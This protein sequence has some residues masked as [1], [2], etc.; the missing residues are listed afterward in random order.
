M[1][2]KIQ[3]G[4]FYE[5]THNVGP[6]PAGV[7]RCR[8]VDD[9]FIVFSVTDKVFFG[10]ERK[11]EKNLRLMSRKAGKLRRTALKD[12]IERYY[13]LLEKGRTK[14]CSGFSLAEFL[15]GTGTFCA[16]DPSV[17]REVQ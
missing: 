13:T 17:A 5:L 6:I 12:F 11:G 1:K 4:H 7:Y 14:S 8:K 15:D 10:M 9:D 3:S 2:K 16:I